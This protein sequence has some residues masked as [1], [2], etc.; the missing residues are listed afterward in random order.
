MSGAKS[1]E[2]VEAMKSEM[3]SLKE[4][5]VWDLV[6]L[7]KGRKVIG[8]KWIF[9]TKVDGDGRIERYKARLVAQGYTQKFGID[10]DQTFSPVVSFESIRSIIA[11]AAKNGLK[12]HQMDIK[13]AFLNG[14]LNEEIF[15]SQPEGF[16]AKGFEDY[17]CKLKRSIYGLKQSARCWNAELDK[18]LKNMGFNQC[19]SDPCIY[20]KE[21]KEGY[22]VIAVYVDDLIVGGE[23]EKNI[24]LT[25]KE[26]SNKFEV[27]DMGPLHY[28]L[29][30]KVVQ[31]PKTSE[32]WI[33]QPNFTNELLHK[34]Q[35]AESKPV[36]TPIDPGVKLSKKL[37][38]EEEYDKV[39]Y[40]SAVG[41]LLYLS[42]RTRPDIAFA[43]GNAARY[44]SQPS[45]THWSAVKRILRYLNGTT[46]LGLLYQPNDSR[47][48]C[49]YS[50]ADWAGDSSDRKSTSGYVFMMSGS[51]VSWRS[52]K[53]SC[54]ALSTAEA[55][56]MALSSATQEAMWMRQ[57][58]ASLVN[59]YKL[60]EPTTIYEDNQSTICMA[61]NNQSH[62]RSK[63]ID[64]KYHFVREQVEQQS[65]KLIYCKSEEMTADI[66]TKGLLNY[67]FKKL[68]SK[69]GMSTQIQEEC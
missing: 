33:G 60:S 27:T 36:D 25:K 42:T 52:K 62:G 46:A 51:A 16:V 37:E 50:D 12:L 66:L 6:K 2:W 14:E 45:Q 43:V 22:C 65:I 44:C 64:I 53:Q 55:E 8:C 7:P 38:S 54:V 31:N 21:T 49:G 69:L 15:I 35:M 13:T 26:I 32:I 23:N 47:E 34:F 48:L 28:F 5:D 67:Q 41:S 58:F 17:V 61:K 63:H 56:Y 11:I 10:Y 3:N 59:E 30:V 19:K 20:I 68:R 9:K 18:K 57:L 24:T 29:G 1:K 40:Q 4:N 39:K